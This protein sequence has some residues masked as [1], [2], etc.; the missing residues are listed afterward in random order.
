MVTGGSILRTSRLV[1]RVFL[2]DHI[3]PEK[4]QGIS[5]RGAPSLVPFGTGL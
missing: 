5:A 1:G 3:A 2:D 4:E